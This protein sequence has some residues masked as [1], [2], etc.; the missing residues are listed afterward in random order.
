MLVIHPASLCD[1]CLDPYIISSEPANSPHAI[2]CLRNLFPSACP[3]CRKSFQPDRV[4]KLHVAGPPELDSV[5]EQSI[6]AEAAQ[7]LQRV[8]L[9]SGEDVPDVEI[10]E[11]VTEVEEWLTKNS[12]DEESHGPLRIALAALQRY[13]A[14]QELNERES[15][16]Y[17]R[18]R[19][20]FKLHR[21][22][23]HQDSKTSR[24]IEE[25]LLGRINEIESKHAMY[26][27]RLHAVID[28]LRGGDN[29]QQPYCN[30]SNPLPPP[31]EPL[32]LDRFPPFAWPGGSADSSDPLLTAVPYPPPPP[33]IQPTSTATTSNGYP[34]V[35]P[36]GGAPHTQYMP[37]VPIA[38]P[39]PI[40]RRPSTQEV[41][42][43]NHPKEGRRQHVESSRTGVTEARYASVDGRSQVVAGTQRPQ[44]GVP[45]PSPAPSWAYHPV[46]EVRSDEEREVRDTHRRVR[47]G[48][49]SGVIS[50]G[51]VDQRPT[52]NARLASAEAYLQGYGSGYES[53]FQIV[54][55]ST[56]FPSSSFNSNR[57][58]RVDG[59][60]VQES[61]VEPIGGLGLMGVPQPSVT[62]TV[63]TPDEDATP[64]SRP[65][66]LTRRNTTMVVETGRS[67]RRP[68]D[69]PLLDI[70]LN[71]GV[72]RVPLQ[73]VN[74][75]LGVRRTVTE[76]AQRHQVIDNNDLMRPQRAAS[77]V[78]APL[79]ADNESPRS[80][81]TWGTVQTLSGDGVSMGSMGS[82]GMLVGLHN[83]GGIRGQGSVANESYTR[84]EDVGDNV[85][86]E[87]GDGGTETPTITG[88]LPGSGSD[89]SGLGL[90]REDEGDYSGSRNGRVEE[91]TTLHHRST[92]ERIPQA[93]EGRQ[94]RQPRARRREGADDHSRYAPQS[95]LAEALRADSHRAAN[96]AN[97]TSANALSLHFDAS[98]PNH[99]FS[100]PSGP[101]IIAP[102]P[103]VGGPNI[104]HLWA[105]RA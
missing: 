26:L 85:A 33:R 41:N 87:G 44:R 90:I 91:S 79:A 63:S 101:E 48:G 28:S 52:V 100:A 12:P 21:R 16:E 45:A 92:S 93:S 38:Q 95:S 55:E 2:A 54:S 74:P 3:L 31:P 13:K 72:R 94:D 96:A 68:G 29:Q 67:A 84:R 35:T 73:T 58:D 97:I 24:A 62:G 6:K 32:P 99:A 61:P 27:S 43:I 57:S 102:T 46:V 42:G 15:A 19:R 64:V 75:V 14:L 60:P 37:P 20:E 10:I 105:N 9:V 7:L 70:P 66:R 78:T 4:K 40:P 71:S 5:V 98:F 8:S 82:L 65:A 59:L 17:R 76:G 11:V 39:A 1:V 25:S 47:V 53:G 69:Q 86:S 34:P 104:I 89:V 30:P 80:E 56:T 36:Y 18:V 103:I 88:S 50:G 51:S 77:G 23:A 81:T 22:N 83:G 49:T